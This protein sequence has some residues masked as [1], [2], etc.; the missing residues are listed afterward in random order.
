MASLELQGFRASIAFGGEKLALHAIEKSEDGSAVTCWI[1]EEEGKK[2]SVK[3]SR[4]HHVFNQTWS[5]ILLADNKADR[6]TCV[7]A[8]EH[9]GTSISFN[10]TFIS[11][12]RSPNLIDGRRV[13]GTPLDG[14]GDIKLEIWRTVIKVVGK[15]ARLLLCPEALRVR[16]FDEPRGEIT[17]TTKLDEHPIASFTFKYRP[18]AVLQAN[19]IVPL[20][21]ADKKRK[22]VDEPME[23]VVS[24][25]QLAASDTARD[26]RVKALEDELRILRSQVFPHLHYMS[27]S[28]LMLDQVDVIM[29]NAHAPAPKTRCLRGVP[30]NTNR[31]VSTH[32]TQLQRSIC[33]GMPPNGVVQNASM[34]DAVRAP[35]VPEQ[36][37]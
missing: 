8:N 17:E 5:A 13:D 28:L 36:R 33:Q 11:R 10:G 25:K 21:A 22:S 30:V 34:V 1:A 7:R 16:M 12:N 19:G 31:F 6:P 4:S 9:T 32:H 37:S 20:L 18:I 2:F 26:A 15:G 29:V 14:L 27:S 24:L 23:D 35:R 3:W